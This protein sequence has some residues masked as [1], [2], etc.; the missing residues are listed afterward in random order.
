MKLTRITIMASLIVGVSALTSCGGGGGKLIDRPETK[1]ENGQFTP[2]LLN[3]LGRVSDPQLSPDGK[4][5]LYG[6]AYEDIAENKSNRELWVMDTDGGN[7]TRLTETP[8]SESNPLWLD[9][10]NKIAFIYKDT[11]EGAKPQLWV[12]NADGSGRKQVS[13]LENGVEGVLFSP[14]EKQVLLIST[15]KYG[16]TPQDIYPDLDKANARIIDDMMYKHWDKW[17]TAIPHPFLAKFDGSTLSDTKDILEGEPY[18]SPMRPWGGTE[19]FAFSPDGKSLT[20]VCRKKTGREYAVSTNS[21]LYRYDIATGKTENLTEGMMGY[22]TNPTYS[23]SGAKLAWL[24]MEHDGYEADKNRIFVMDTKSGEKRDLTADW[25]YSVDAIAWSADEK[26]LYFLAPFQGT[27]PLFRIDV[28]TA[29]VDTVAA[30]MADY[31]AL[32]P[33]ADGKVVTLRHSFLEPNEVF[34][35]ELGKEPVQLTHVND[36]LLKQLDPVTCE[37]VMVPTTDGKQMTTWVLLPPKFD[38]SKKYPSILF[39]EGGPQSPVS[40]FW[41]YRWNLR[42][43]ASQGYVVIA[44]NRRGLPGFGT[45]WNAQISTDYGGQNMQDYLSAANYMKQQEYIDGEHMGAVGAS[46]GGYSVYFLAGNHNKTFA[47]FLAHAGIFNLEAQYLETEEMWFVNWDLGGPFWEKDNAAAQKTY[48]TASP[49]RFVQNWDTPIMITAGELDYRIV[50]TQ[51]T[52]AF[53]AARLRD[54]PAKMVLFPDENHWILQPQNSIL[55]QREFFG[56][57]DT[58]LKPDSPARKQ[59]DARQDS[60]AARKKLEMAQPVADAQQP[61]K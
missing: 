19:S 23:K 25:D 57:L 31:A 39:C 15:V 61:V 8:N 18:E 54:I 38:K 20:Y 42:L 59:Y 34:L 41:S 27:I 60:I 30:G 3:A 6:V 37:K 7:A 2:E 21:D 13:D 33:M 51:A 56:W 26:Y 5:I 44:P 11:K 43:M 58:W 4:K 1:V 9:G 36:D 46:Y 22:D 52:Q 50:F 45:E 49:H 35:A 16:E 48:A 47:C 10:G 14:D 40:Q 32:V 17:V 29:K 55:W 28:E 24:S 12:M 53:N